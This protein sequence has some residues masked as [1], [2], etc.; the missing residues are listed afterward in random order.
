MSGDLVRSKFVV[1]SN[2]LGKDEPV[3]RVF[4]DL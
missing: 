4:I 1:L 2:D 3:K